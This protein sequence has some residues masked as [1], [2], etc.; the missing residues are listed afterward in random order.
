MAPSSG[1]GDRFVAWLEK[2]RPARAM[3]VALFGGIILGAIASTL[4]AT[5]YWPPVGIF[6][7][8]AWFFLVLFVSGRDSRGSKQ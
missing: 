4:I 1:G 2:P 3:V 6:I 7:G 8:F 5:A